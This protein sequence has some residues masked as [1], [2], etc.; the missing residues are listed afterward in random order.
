MV[1]L[2]E[3]P[4]RAASHTPT[5]S[6]TATSAIWKGREICA[7]FPSFGISAQKL[8]GE[9]THGRLYPANKGFSRPLA[10]CGSAPIRAHAVAFAR[11]VNLTAADVPEATVSH[12]KKRASATGERGELDRCE[13][14]GHVGG[15]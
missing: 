9:R 8:N 12:G 5:S 14:R 4:C 3:C 10:A 2:F 7:I 13:A 15:L 6:T 11:A 1:A